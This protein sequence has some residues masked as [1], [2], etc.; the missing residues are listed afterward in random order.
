MKTTRLG[1]IFFNGPILSSFLFYFCTFHITIQLQ[2]E[3]SV[4][5]ELGIRTR[6]RIMVGTHRST[7]LWRPPGSG[8]YFIKLLIFVVAVV[9]AAKRFELALIMAISISKLQLSHGCLENEMQ[10]TVAGGATFRPLIFFSKVGQPWPLFRLILVSPNKQVL[11]QINVK[12]TCPFSIQC[13]DLN[14]RPLEHESSPITSRQGLPPPV[15]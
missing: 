11:Q 3:K 2:T 13:R 5:V 9:D 8:L 12:M 14:P 7:E 1:P 6:G 4:N 15:H 10:R